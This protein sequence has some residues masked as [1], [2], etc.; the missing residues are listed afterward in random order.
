MRRSRGPMTSIEQWAK[1]VT[2]DQ[3]E[4][5]RDTPNPTQARTM[6]T[7]LQ[8]MHVD[9]SPYSRLPKKYVITA[10]NLE[11]S[12]V[13]SVAADNI[14]EAEEAAI[15]LSM[16][17]AAKTAND[18]TIT[19]DSRTTIVNYLQGLLLARIAFEMSSRSFQQWTDD[20]QFFVASFTFVLETDESLN[21]RPDI[22]VFVEVL[23]ALGEA[24]VLLITDLSLQKD[25]WAE[26]PDPVDRFAAADAKRGHTRPVSAMLPEILSAVTG[27][28]ATRDSF[29]GGR[30]E[31]GIE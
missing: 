14:D 22:L 1:Q 7:R 27:D 19:T 3:R 28:R 20:C 15:A 8:N 18:S 13:A 5:I 17:A 11:H 30:R 26:T 29:R 23:L 21:L 4:A 12:H 25:A 2:E 9:A 6:D 31:T 10:F 24:D 16:L